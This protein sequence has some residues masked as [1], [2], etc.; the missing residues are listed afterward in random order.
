MKLHGDFRYDSVKN[1]PSDL[2]AQNAELASCFTIA[3]SRFGLIVAGY[4][5]RDH[6]VMNL[7]RTALSAPDAFPHGLYWTGIKGTAPLPAVR[8][9]LE[10]AENSGIRA[11][12]VEIET[13]DSFMLRL[14]RSLDNKPPELDAKI[15]RALPASVS[16]PLPSAGSA[17]PL[18]RLNALPV[19][20]LPSRC[21]EIKLKKPM[22]WAEIRKVQAETEPRFVFT[23]ADSIWCWGAAAEI[24]EAF[25]K[26]L[27]ESGAGDLPLEG[28]G[29]DSLHVKAFLEEAL[30]VALARGRPLIPRSKRSGSYLIVDGHARDQGLLDP[31]FQAV[32]K[33]SGTI[34]GL[35]APVD[36]DHPEPQK[37]AWAEA[38]HL[39]LTGKEDRIWLLIQPDIWIWPP[40][41]REV[42]TDFLDRRR[43]KRFNPK[44]NE[45]LDA[46]VRVLIG[47]TKRGASATF[48]AFDGGTA[49]ENPRFE[50]ASTTAYT[51]RLAS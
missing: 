6:S 34:S 12:Y 23:K 3:S 38:L 45:L 48:T 46:W 20:S 27:L 33:T 29:P 35:F 32:G 31:I 37:V 15:R 26:N 51:R 4:S 13:F 9:L 7:L 41:A 36:E 42:A 50:L 14:W 24:E 47:S 8:Q 17:K 39:S 5:G 40:R 30:A 18:V 2:E 28:W 19:L 49:E 10:E 11:A 21:L 25:G 43:A 44:H 22:D 1:L 16:I